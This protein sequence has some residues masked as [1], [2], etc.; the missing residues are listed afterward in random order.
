MTKILL[1]SER[2]VSTYKENQTKISELETIQEKLKDKNQNKKSRINSKYYDKIRALEKEQNKILNDLENKMQKINSNYEK[3]ISELYNPI[4]DVERI[5]Y[6]LNQE[7]LELNFDCTKTTNYNDRHLELIE[8]YT[9][10]HLK[11]G[12]YIAENNRP[13]NK[14][15][16]II[17]GICRFGDHDRDSKILKLPYDYGVSLY[18]NEIQWWD[19][20]INLKRFDSIESAKKYHESHKIEKILKSFLVEYHTIL[21]EYE[22]TINS[23]SLKDFA[24]IIKTED[25]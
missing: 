24:E 17:C 10:D 4:T 3:K 2:L 8:Q 9:K 22:E 15:S 14:Y 16:L 11:L 13:K 19:I 12:C 21:E 6:F 5:I 23:Y 20:A 25:D 18:H 1:S 7:K